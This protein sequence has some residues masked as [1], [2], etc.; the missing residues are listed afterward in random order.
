MERGDDD[1]DV[2]HTEQL[3][4]SSIPFKEEVGGRRLDEGD[5]NIDNEDAE[6]DRRG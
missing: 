4:P 1:L 3:P 5:E 6:R 2:E